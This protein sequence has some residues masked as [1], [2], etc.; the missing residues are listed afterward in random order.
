MGLCT[1][2]SHGTKTPYWMANDAVRQE[3]QRDALI[4][5]INTVEPPVSLRTANV[6]PV[7]ASRPPKNFSEGEKRR[8][9]IRLRFAG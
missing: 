6:F 1:K 8:P 7:V 2:R 3:K 5:K 4:Q 9:E